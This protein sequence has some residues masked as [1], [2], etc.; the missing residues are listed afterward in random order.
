[1][2]ALALE[3][4]Q[5]LRRVPPEACGALVRKRGDGS[6]AG[7]VLA[8]RGRV[9]WVVSAS[10]PQ[11]LAEHIATESGS[12]TREQV[13]EL[14]A[15][16]RR[17]GTPLGET[18]LTRGL[19][20]VPVL[21][22]AL[23]N[24]SCESFGHLLRD[25]ALPW[26]WIDHSSHGYNPLLTF[27]PVEV[28]AGVQA[29]EVPDRAGRAAARL[30]AVAL[31]GQGGLAIERGRGRLPLAQQGCSA[32]DLTALGDL[33]RHADEIAALSAAVEVRVAVSELDGG[34]AA[35]WVEDDLLFVLLCNG[36]LA[37]NRLLSHVASL[38]INN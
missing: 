25:D 2:T 30:R 32:L 5:V 26:A 18:L 13:S 15:L 17:D 24:H 21:H 10:A 7:A 27:S 36:E 23:L 16:C 31:P 35:S 38:T 4:Y 8:E 1:M 6:M 9:C 11:R 19:V 37:F 29:L 33:A 3:A 12:L 20:S 28:I 14:A 34:A 22:R